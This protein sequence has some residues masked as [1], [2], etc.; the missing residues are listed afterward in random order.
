MQTN[1]FEK[2]EIFRQQIHATYKIFKSIAAR[3]IKY[4][5]KSFMQDFD[6]MEI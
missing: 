5:Y 4:S 6:V 2:H 3:D 1:F